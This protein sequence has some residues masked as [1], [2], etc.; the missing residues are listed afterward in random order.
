[1]LLAYDDRTAVRLALE[2][3]GEAA[4]PER[5]SRVEERKTARFAQLIPEVPVFDG[6]RELIET[7]ADE[8]P[9]AIASGARHEEIEAILTG[10]GL[11][12][13]FSAIVGADDA[14]RTKPDPAPYVEAARQLVAQA[15]GLTPAQCVAFED[16]PPGI[17]AALGA[18]MRVVAVAH[19][20]PAEKL[21]IASLVVGSLVGLAAGELRG[22]FQ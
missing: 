8:M 19:T 13:A 5:I 4:P 22:L 10:V 15:P 11:R 21:S 16:T 18:G 7:L 6:A 1:M 20:Y 14:A 2:H 17:A 9:L 12:A 3:H